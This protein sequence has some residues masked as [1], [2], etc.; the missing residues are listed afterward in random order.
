MTQDTEIIERR[1]D[2][3][4]HFANCG[5]GFIHRR[6]PSDVFYRT[7]SAGEKPRGPSCVGVVRV[8]QAQPRDL[9]AALGYTSSMRRT[10]RTLVPVLMN[11]S[12]GNSSQ[13]PPRASTMGL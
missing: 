3:L 11:V 10:V 2:S 9:R 4:G 6:Y 12:G 1:L 7:R 13:I 8:L 5:F